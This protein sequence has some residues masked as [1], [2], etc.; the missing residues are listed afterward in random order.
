MKRT[1]FL[2]TTLTIWAFLSCSISI[3]Q[4]QQ[5]AM[6]EDKTAFSLQ[7]CIDFALENNRQLIQAGMDVKIAEEQVKEVIGTGLPQINAE[8]QIS[9]S[10]K[11]QRAILPAQFAGG[12]EGDPDVAIPFGV[13]YNGNAAVSVNQLLFDGTFFLGLK[14][15]RVFQ[16][17]SEKQ[18]VA[19]KIDLVENVINGYYAVLVT[20]ER[21]KLLDQNIKNLNSL[22]EQTELQYKEGFVEKNDVDRLQVSLNNIKTEKTK[23]K[24]LRDYSLKLLLAVMGKDVTDQVVLSE[25]LDDIDASALVIDESLSRPVEER[26]EFSII[27]TNEDLKGFQVKQE[28]VGY[29][30][31]LYAFGQYG[32]NDGGSQLSDM[33]NWFGS[34]MLGVSLRFPIFDGLQRHRRIQQ[35][36]LEVL[37]VEQQKKDLLNQLTLEQ[38]QT[39]DDLESSIEVLKIQKQN[40]E[41]AARVYE[42][43]KIKFEEG[44]GSS[45][46]I[47]DAETSYRQASTQ[48]YSSLYDALI[49]KV[50]WEKA[51]GI[52]YTE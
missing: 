38:I 31:G 10:P 40:M 52:L 35:R 46:E 37:K 16:S 20:D 14:A 22:Y 41:L 21:L 34:S 12:A 44:L 17:L 42:H 50:A 3:A 24:Y 43:S 5:N 51:N 28:Q 4:A 1:A 19:N 39:R 8:G 13:A 36:K 15:S 45:L 32:W 27:N 2:K 6:P 7:E 23:S 11:I 29:L 48:Y 9:Y 49:S 47:T 18:L 33:N 26:I 25:T 30:P